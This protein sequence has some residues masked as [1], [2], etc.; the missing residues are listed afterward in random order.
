M[1]S[2]DEFNKRE[3]EFWERTDCLCENEVPTEI[4]C[5]G[6]PCKDLCSWLEANDPYLHER[7]ESKG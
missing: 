1:E 6:C 7:N 5:S 4:L 3:A 2:I